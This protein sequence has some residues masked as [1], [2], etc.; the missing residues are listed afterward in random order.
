MKNLS[1]FIVFVFTLTS[2]SCKNEVD[3]EIKV[4]T[5]EEMQTI[6]KMDEVQLVDVRTPEEFSEGYIKNAQNID[7][8]SP[9]FDQDILKLNKEKYNLVCSWVQKYNEHDWHQ[10]HVHDVNDYS[11]IYFI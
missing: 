1:L 7:F 9:T 4:V 6:L 8:N 3:S 10:T 5:T 11:F 2:F